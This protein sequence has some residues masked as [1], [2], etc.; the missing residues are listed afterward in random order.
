MKA[1]LSIA[2][3]FVAAASSLAFAAAADDA[4]EEMKNCAV[5]KVMAA[6]PDLMKSMTYECHKIDAG[7]ICV[8]TVPKEQKEKYDSIQAKMKASVAQVKADHA[9]GKEVHLCSFCKGVGELEQAGAK[10]E[11]V[12]TQ[13]GSVFLVTATDPSV[14]AKIHTH[15][16]QAIAQMKAMETAQR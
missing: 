5:C 6:D 13:T 12:E 14:V 9:A 8:A 3:L 1:R 15:A 11:T 2:A 7:M 10:E 16:D 4:V